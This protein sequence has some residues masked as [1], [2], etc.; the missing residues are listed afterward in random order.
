[1]VG[2][3]A[4]KSRQARKPP[5]APNSV[6]GLLSSRPIQNTARC[7]PVKPANQL[8][9]MSLLVPVLPAA[10]SEA[11]AELPIALAVPY[12]ATC[13]IAQVVSRTASWYS[14]GPGCTW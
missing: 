12:S 8:S 11:S 7:W 14:P 6:V 9:R 13:C 3:L 2:S 10:C 4:N 5:L 1:M